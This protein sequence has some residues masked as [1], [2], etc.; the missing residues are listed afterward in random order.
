VSY[1]P[2]AIEESLDTNLQFESHM[3]HKKAYWSF[4]GF[5]NYV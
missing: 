1:P 4:Y 3:P 2:L 5:E